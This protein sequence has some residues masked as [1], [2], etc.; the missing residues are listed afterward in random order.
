MDQK[1]LKRL[2]EILSTHSKKIDAAKLALDTRNTERETATQAFFAKNIKDVI[3][4][5]QEIR[6]RMANAGHAGKIVED[7]VDG[8][9]GRN[10]RLMFV[11]GLDGKPTNPSHG[12]ALGIKFSLNLVA[13]E[14]EVHYTTSRHTGVEERSTSLNSYD[15][16]FAIEQTTKF[17]DKLF[18]E[19]DGR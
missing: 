15:A 19:T 8:G 2:D 9:D 4:A 7:W 11:V 10:P 16:D 1:Q 18:E 13:K 6:L 5:L 14:V 17:L 3:P 12:S